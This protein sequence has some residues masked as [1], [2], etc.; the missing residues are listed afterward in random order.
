MTV[1][2]IVNHL[3]EYKMITTEAASVLLQAE[4]KAMMFDKQDRN[5]NTVF[6]PFLGV[7]NGTTANPYYYSTTTNDPI[8]GTL[9]NELLKVK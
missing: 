3:L 1:S 7:P 8:V 4:I 6:Q 9:S 5:T 2:E